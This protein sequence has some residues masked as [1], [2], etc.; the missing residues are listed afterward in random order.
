MTNAHMLGHLKTGDLVVAPLRDWNIPVVHAQNVALLLLDTDLAHGVISPGRLIAT[1]GDTG[2]LR[3]VNGTGKASKSAPAAADIQE[4]LALLETD[5]LAH[6]SQL[7]VLELLK[8]LLG[9]DVGDDSGGVDHTGTQEPGVE[10]ISSIIV[11]SYLLLV[12][13]R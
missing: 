5:L 3:A 9:I 2:S 13:L 7:V 4:S 8:A 6:D 12:Y 1:K 10:I 11:I